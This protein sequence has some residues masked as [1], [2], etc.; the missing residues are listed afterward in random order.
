MPATQNA[1]AAAI[2]SAPSSISIA[3]WRIARPPTRGRV[4]VACPND[5]PQHKEGHHGDYLTAQDNAVDVHRRA[6]T[7]VRAVDHVDAGRLGHRHAGPAADPGAAGRNRL[8]RTLAVHAAGGATTQLRDE[9]PGPCA[10]AV[11]PNNRDTVSA[12]RVCC[13]SSL[14]SIVVSSRRGPSP[15][16]ATTRAASDLIDQVSSSDEH[17]QTAAQNR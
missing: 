1:A 8:G 7:H 3:M 10:H 11:R 5:A 2:A 16:D 14:T 12:S 9:P 17:R 6:P 13:M 4:S 15:S